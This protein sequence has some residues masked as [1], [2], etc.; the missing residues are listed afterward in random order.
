[1]IEHHN[2]LV[3]EISNKS[4]IIFCNREEAEAFTK[5]PENVRILKKT[6]IKILIN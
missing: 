1:M 5:M 2:E 3:M 4:D 6:H